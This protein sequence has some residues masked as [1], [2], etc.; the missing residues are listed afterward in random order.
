MP[1]YSND[2]VVIRMRAPTMPDTQAGEAPYLAL[3]A[4]AG[5][6]LVDL[7]VRPVVHGGQPVPCG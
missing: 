2:L 3:A 7:S 4:P 5:Q 6:V 1:P